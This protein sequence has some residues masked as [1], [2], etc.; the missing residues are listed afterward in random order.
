MR[1]S[2][3]HD[4]AEDVRE[5]H[6]VDEDL[7]HVEHEG[8]DVADLEDALLTEDRAN[9]EDGGHGA[10]EEEI[11]HH[12]EQRDP[13]GLLDTYLVHNLILSF[14]L[15]S[16]LLLISECLDS[17]DVGEALLGQGRNRRLLVLHNLLRFFHH[18]PEEY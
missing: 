15:S 14:E 1:G 5:H 10:E 17:P 2:Y 12:V 4:G 16:L 6:E 8:R 13:D 11:G 9:Q 18:I 7:N 3:S